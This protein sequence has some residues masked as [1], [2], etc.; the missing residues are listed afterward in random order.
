MLF[1]SKWCIKIIWW[2]TGEKSWQTNV[3]RHPVEKHCHTLMWII[4]FSGSTSSRVFSIR[5]SDDVAFASGHRQVRRRF[6]TGKVSWTRSRLELYIYA[7]QYSRP[8]LFA[9]FF[10]LRICLFTLKKV[11]QMAIFQSK[12]DFLFVNSRFGVLNDGTYLSRITRDTCIDIFSWGYEA[13][14]KNIKT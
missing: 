14:A 1:S 10:Y 8:S 11:V 2:R 6:E 5:P 13:Y 4:L 7:S 12:I 3:S 9:E